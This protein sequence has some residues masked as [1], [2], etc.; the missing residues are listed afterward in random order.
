MSQPYRD[1]H[2]AL[3]TRLT[4]LEQDLEGLRAKKQEL[5]EAVGQEAELAKEAEAVR[6]RLSHMRARRALPLLE[7]LRIASP[8]KADWTQMT[9]DEA[10][11]FCGSCEKNVYDL[12]GM[13][14]D[15]AEAFVRAREGAGAC[16]R[17]HKRADGTVITSDCPVGVGNARKRRVAAVAVGAALVGGGA[18][19]F[20]GSATVMGEL[21]VSEPRM[22]QVVD[23][24]P[25]HQ[26][27]MG[28]MPPRAEPPSDPTAKPQGS[29]GAAAPK[30][31][32][33]PEVGWTPPF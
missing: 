13:T 10:V 9:G 24:G 17:L 20:A 21:E 15:Q 30:P 5:E 29:S 1:D 27:V 8:C 11:R 31:P 4:A 25:E 3:E 18:A 7:S 23:T 19:M 12:S 33:P 6:R 28:L 2:E 16:I 14:R 32:T 22:G 26:V